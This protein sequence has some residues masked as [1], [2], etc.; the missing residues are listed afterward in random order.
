[1]VAPTQ[2]AKQSAEALLRTISLPG[3]EEA[4]VV[5]HSLSPHIEALDV[6]QNVFIETTFSEDK[7]LNLGTF[8]MDDPRNTLCSWIESSGSSCELNAAEFAI[9]RLFKAGDDNFGSSTLDPLS[10]KQD[11][12]ASHL[13]F[14]SMDV[15]KREA[16]CVK[17][18][19]PQAMRGYFEQISLAKHRII[20]GEFL[21]ANTMERLRTEE[22]SRR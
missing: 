11:M 18:W 20:T 9:V 10:D 17:G 22:N 1:V 16:P 7:L 2:E 19:K 6:I 4:K 5:L 21:D 14:I 13:D 8:M 15:L 3:L 12:F